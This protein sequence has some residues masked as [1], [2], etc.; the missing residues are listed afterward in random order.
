MLFKSVFAPFWSHA[1]MTIFLRFYFLYFACP[2]LLPLLKVP[3]YLCFIFLVHNRPSSSPAD[4]FA[5]QKTN[6]H[7]LPSKYHFQ[8][9]LERPGPIQG[10]RWAAPDAYRC[11]L[12]YTPK[13][14]TQALALSAS[15][16]QVY[17]VVNALLYNE[18]YL[19]A[20]KVKTPSLKSDV[21]H[22]F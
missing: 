16:I 14:H 10:R 17:P 9:L 5:L 21:L 1:R 7:W 19:R 13:E 6:W 2:L 20:L 11:P 3:F 8:E 22:C 12:L 4:C 18:K 15:K